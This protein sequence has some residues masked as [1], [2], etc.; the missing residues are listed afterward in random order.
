MPTLR[1]LLVLCTSAGLLSLT[2]SSLAPA[3]PRW[4]YKRALSPRGQPS[5]S[6]GEQRCWPA[7]R[8]GR[9][10][11]AAAAA[12]LSLYPWAAEY[13]RP[14]GGE[15]S[16]SYAEGSTVYLGG[17]SSGYPSEC[18]G[19]GAA[20]ATGYPSGFSGWATAVESAG[21]MPARRGWLSGPSDCE[22]AAVTALYLSGGKQRLKLRWEPSMPQGQFT[23]EMWLNPEG[24]QDNPAIVAG[25]FDNCSYSLGEKGWMV[26]IQSLENSGRKDPR[27]FFTLR[28][29]RARKA[30]TV[31][32]HHN[33]QPNTWTYLAVSYDGHQMLLYIN[34]ARVGASTGQL[35]DLHNIFMSSCRTLLIGGDRSR[36]GHSFRGYLASFS[37]WKTA[38]SQAELVKRYRQRTQR[39]DASLVLVADFSRMEEQWIPDKDC[40]YPTRDIVLLPEPVLA[41]PLI[42]PLCG[43]T[44]CDNIDVIKN[45]NNY[46]PLRGEK[47][48]CYRVI[49]VYD[50]KRQNPTVTKQQIELQHQ[51][52]NR[53]FSR[54][55]ITWDLT[56]TEILNST[57][58]NRIILVNCEKSKIGNDHCDPECDH[59]LTGYDGGDCR[60]LGRCYVWKRRD[61]VCNMECNNFLDNFDDGD[62]CNPMF[63]DVRKTCFDPDS[64]ERTYMSVKELKETLQ[65][66][67]SMYLNVY[68][69]NSVRE[70]LAGAATWP[71]DKEALSYLGGVVLSPTCYG[72]PGHTNTM[73]HELGHILGLFH[74][75]KGVSEKESC[76]DPCRETIP[77]METGDLCEDTAPTVNSKVCRDPD[78][79]NDTCGQVR[80]SGTPFNNYMSYTD[81]SCTNN[82]SP[83][84]VARMHCYLDL[85]YQGWI[86]SKKPAPISVA[87]EVIGQT[88][89]SVTIHWLP[90]IS[91]MLYEREVGTL[92]GDCDEDGKFY[93]YAHTA[94][95][96]RI[97]DKPGYWTPEEAVGAP[98]VDEPC[99]PSLQAWSPELHL[100]HMNMSVPC[101]Q[102]DG[103]MLE[104]HFAYPVVAD[105]LSVWVIYLSAG[106]EKGISAIKIVTVDKQE[107]QLGGSYHTFCNVPLSV[108]VNVK[109]KVAGVKIYTFDE[110]MELD[111]VL[112]TSRSQDPLCNM[113]KSLKY[114]IVREP[115]FHKGRMLTVTQKERTF[116]DWEVVPGRV[117]S[118]QVKVTAGSLSSELTPPLTYAHGSPFCGDQKV[119]RNLGEEC[120]DG[121]LLDGDGCS[122]KCQKEEKF[123][124]VGEPSLCY[125]YDGD[126]ICEEFE[127]SKSIHDCGFATPKGFTDQWATGALTSHQDERRCPVQM[128]TGQPDVT[129]VCQTAFLDET[130]RL[131]QY[132]WFPC[133]ASFYTANVND[134]N[135]PHSYHS[136][137]DEENIWLKVFFDRPDVASSIV[138]Y[139]SADGTTLFDQQRKSIII[140][141]TD[142]NGRNHTLGTYELSCKKNPLIINV[143]H[144]LD[145]NLHKIASVLLNGS[146]PFVAVSGVA[147][148]VSN[149]LV[150]TI[151]PNCAKQEGSKDHKQRY[152]S[153]SCNQDQCKTLSVNHA[154]VNCIEDHTEHMQCH[155][156]CA[157]GLSLKS[158]C[159]KHLSL[160]QTEVSLFCK[161]GKWD[162]AVTCEPID[163]G[164]PDHSHVYHATFFCP[165]GTTFGSRCIF[166]C[167]PPAILQGDNYFLKCMEDGLWSFPEA[168]CKVECLAPP[169]VTNARLLVP[170]CL[171]GSHDVGSICRYKCNP[172][173]Y[174]H[175]TNDKRS[176]KRFL[177]LQCLEGGYWEE[178]GCNPVL[179]DRP[180]LVFEGMYSCTNGFEFDTRCIITCYDHTKKGPIRCTKDGTWTEDFTLCDQVHGECLPPPELNLVEYRCVDGYKIG[181]MCDASCVIPPSDV[182]VLPSNVTADTMVHWMEP[183]RVQ[184]IVCT[185]LLQ[186][187]PKPHLIHC[188]QSCEPFQADGWCD[189]INNRAFCQYDG[190]DCCPSTLSSRKVIPF[191]ADCDDQDECTCRDPN[192]EEN[193]Q[194]ERQLGFH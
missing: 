102:P 71:W 32:A 182:V 46:W 171:Q 110:K 101:P 66:N 36:E 144:K 19:A 177:K 193:L 107:I 70:E 166:S 48:M 63:T 59:P 30:S 73:I 135:K 9:S 126:G 137:N 47:L 108:K 124:C 51:V 61:E 129:K 154:T 139:L 179:C 85:V 15:R 5:L 44:V 131:S 83:N 104:V 64:P 169:P 31:F 25:L 189:T 112:L 141:F 6:P 132:A 75:F 115:P 105:S 89:D 168:F 190:G 156:A 77:S 114:K 145:F 45:Y 175:G 142:T 58:R 194:K 43:L 185:G 93:Q 23:A 188:I 155:L 62:C 140:Q 118:Y 56:V 117:Y 78:P 159:G 80:Y 12:Q 146:S 76:D 162:G 133:T 109:R 21:G 94:S 91:G 60:Y 95:S 8:R 153:C 54:Y 90:P 13:G 97:C 158:V 74:V 181:S 121:N 149:H 192:A 50:D 116:T 24:G 37:L 86:H 82:F 123:N 180:P 33:Y 164:I 81:D 41:S 79:V 113:C 176:R 150:S 122:R 163:C 69:A 100:Q 10:R 27:F 34:G 68:F 184:S 35:G 125:V 134:F 7:G 106:L 120:D 96:P 29:D 165:E 187:Y 170:R 183:P 38:K 99:E 1:L 152:A 49:N 127:K 4:R 67:G 14:G 40:H 130:A 178:G 174:I 16:G 92:C 3:S 103:C 173:Y 87:P 160:L 119:E 186:W 191:A 11:R 22:P 84:Q 172:G 151:T 39:G 55:N 136:V 148:R 17:E 88:P 138:I 167:N 26:G 20:R 53:A 18:G 72:R 147:L 161:H 111:A 128:V 65:I 2:L 57:I 28:T 42:P 157:K 52:L 143:P 98:D